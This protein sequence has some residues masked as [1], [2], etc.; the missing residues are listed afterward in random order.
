MQGESHP[1]YC[2]RCGRRFELQDP[3]PSERDLAL[4]RIRT[5][6]SYCTSCRLFVGRTCCWNPELVACTACVSFE[7]GGGSADPFVDAASSS[8]RVASRALR[9]L[10]EAVDDLRHLAVRLA[11]PERVGRDRSVQIWQS[12]WSTAG[13]LAVRAEASRDA[14]ALAL[15]QSPADDGAQHAELTEQLRELKT[16]YSAARRGIEGRLS[17]A[18]SRLEAEAVSPAQESLPSRRISLLAGGLLA[19]I[20]AALLVAGGFAIVW[21]RPELSVLGGGGG[22]SASPHTLGTPAPSARSQPQARS[23]LAEMHFDLLRV[24]SLQGASNT[25]AVIAGNDEVVP[26]PSPFDR[27]VRM[28]GAGQHRFCVDVDGL[29]ADEISVALDVYTDA[30]L[31][32]LLDLTAVPGDGVSSS[33]SYS[34]E[35][36]GQLLPRRWYRLVSVWQPGGPAAIEVHEVGGPRL[37]SQTLS[38]KAA[39]AG[40]PLGALCVSGSGIADGASLMLDNLLVKQ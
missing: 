14:A 3:Q 27:S 32:G 36:L 11:S 5:T 9:D 37:L 26:F 23:V 13:W 2:E 34:S 38:T 28:R 19:A 12:A 21:T 7:R 31:S 20:T 15:G 6:F 1:S 33:V 17:A 8:K 16:A 24:G 22:P 29:K 18:G 25:I 30:P 39:Q 40:P 35:L 4:D 10:A